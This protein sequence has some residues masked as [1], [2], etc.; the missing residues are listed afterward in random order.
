LNSLT[1]RPSP[2]TQAQNVSLTA[3]L[4]AHEPP[5]STVT[6]ELGEA[7][8][9]A[10]AEAP[11]PVLLLAPLLQAAS[12]VTAATVAIAATAMPGRLLAPR[13]VVSV[14]SGLIGVR[15]FAFS[16]WARPP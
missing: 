5:A 1:A 9:L 6:V 14:P 2:G 7:E 13:L 12:P 11:A 15:S 4:D 16:L 8:P 10:L 3:L